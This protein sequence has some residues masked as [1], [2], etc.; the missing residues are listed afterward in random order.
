MDGEITLPH[1]GAKIPLPHYPLPIQNP[2]ENKP[3]IQNGIIY[4]SL[5]LFAKV[6]LSL[7]DAQLRLT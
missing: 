7:G 2:K 5:L 6:L 3:E 1:L 4:V